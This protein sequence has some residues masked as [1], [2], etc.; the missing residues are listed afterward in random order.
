METEELNRI[1]TKIENM[2]KKNHLQILQLLKNYNNI[3]LNEN[4][5]GTFIN[6]NE[7]DK[8]I[9]L[10]LEKYIKYIDI[11]KQFLDKDEKVKDNLE[12]KYFK[13]N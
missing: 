2:E 8:N 11:Q 4:N 7:L 9:I 6:M 1:K 12:N 10:E 5:N 3:T 13:W